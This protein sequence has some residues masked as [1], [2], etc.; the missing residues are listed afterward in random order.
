MKHYNNIT[1]YDK[2]LLR[3][4][5]NVTKHIVVTSKSAINA[6]HSTFSRGRCCYSQYYVRILWFGLAYF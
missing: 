2:E 1:I 4:H 3:L 6:T 5:H